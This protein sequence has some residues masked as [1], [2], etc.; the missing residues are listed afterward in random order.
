VADH[1]TGKGRGEKIDAVYVST[2]KRI[3]CSKKEEVVESN[4]E[5]Y[6]QKIRQALF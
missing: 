1:V 3:R 2:E 5:K 4:E 6:I